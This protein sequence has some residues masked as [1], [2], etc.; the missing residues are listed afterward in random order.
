MPRARKRGPIP[1]PLPPGDKSRVARKRAQVCDAFVPE[2]CQVAALSWFG[3]KPGRVPSE[4]KNRHAY[5]PSQVCRAARGPRCPGLRFACGS[6]V[7]R[8]H[9]GSPGRPAGPRP[10]LGNDRRSQGRRHDQRRQ[11]LPA[12][13]RPPV[14][15]SSAPRCAKPPDASACTSSVAARSGAARVAGRRR[16]SVPARLARLPLGD[17]R[18][19]PRRPHRPRAAAVPALGRHPPGRSRRL[20]HDRRP[21]QASRNVP[22]AACMAT[23]G[24]DRLVVRPARRP[25]PRGDRHRR[26]ATHARRRGCSGTRR[27]RRP[28]AAAGE[29]GRRV[30]SD[31]VR[32]CTPTSRRSTPTAARPSPPA[33]ESASSAPPG[34]RPARTSTSRSGCAAPPSI[35]AAPCR[36][37]TGV[38][39]FPDGR[40]SRRAAGVR[41]RGRPARRRLERRSAP[42]I[43]PRGDR[44]EHPAARR[45][46]QRRRPRC[47]PGASLQRADAPSGQHHG[48]DAQ[49]GLQAR[50]PGATGKRSE[51][52][53]RTRRTDP[54]RLVGRRA[55]LRQDLRRHGVGRRLGDRRGPAPDPAVDP[56][57]DGT[58]LDG[59]PYDLTRTL[60]PSAATENALAAQEHAGRRLGKK[61]EILRDVDAYTAGINAYLKAHQPGVSPGRAMTRS[62]PPRS[63]APSTAPAAATRPAAPSSPGRSHRPAR[64]DEGPPGLGRPARAART[65]R[66]L[67]PPRAPSR[68]ATHERGGN[69]LLDAGT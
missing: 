66:H 48:E 45:V 2:L 58:R 6:V 36:K 35:R 64:P 52:R 7:Q 34:T 54:A 44:A 51:S 14:D 12:R 43:R 16:A 63:S 24:A 32:P 69:V 5:L 37:P 23:K 50:D 42:S 22:A 39:S 3:L 9:R 27:L 40:E 38:G 20:E 15:G 53:P 33:L 68:S 4:N 30:Y 65:R 8:R 62:R 28:P 56:R 29:P 57:T 67:S 41:A 46:G 55:C 17:D 11:A 31:G 47:R 19:R 10:V 61:G 21:P 26:A 59:P 49:E 60:V 13:R 25:V 18:R 1:N